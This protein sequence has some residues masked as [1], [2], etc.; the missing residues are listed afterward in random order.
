[1]LKEIL[2]APFGHIV[3]VLGENLNCNITLDLVE[4]N[5]PKPGTKFERKV[6]V[7]ASDLPIIRAVIR[8]DKQT[9]PQ[10]LIPELLKKRKLIGTLLNLNGIQVK[11]TVTSMFFDKGE[12][13]LFRVYEI[14]NDKKILFEVSEEIKINHLNSVRG[15]CLIPS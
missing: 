9:L 2:D 8:F 11:K 4:Q 7:S 13:S 3:T 14:R 12:N 5:T 1:M 10:Q 15:H 6:I